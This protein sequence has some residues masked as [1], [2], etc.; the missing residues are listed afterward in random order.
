MNVSIFL[1]NLMCHRCIEVSL[2]AKYTNHIHLT[3]VISQKVF[4]WTQQKLN[5]SSSVSGVLRRVLAALTNWITCWKIYN[6][7]WTNNDTWIT[8]TWKL[9]A[10]SFMLHT[11]KYQ[12]N[13]L[14]LLK[15]KSKTPTYNHSLPTRSFN[16]SY[17]N[18]N[19][20]NSCDNVYGA[21]IIA[22]NC[23]CKS[24]PGSFGHSSTSARRLP[25]FG[26]D[27]SNPPVGSYKYYTNHRHLLLLILKADTH[28]TIPRRVE[29]WVDLAGWLHNKMVYLPVDSHPSQY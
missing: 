18:S 6:S 21:V 27:R 2:M 4:N 5:T 14:T 28:F 25:T 29:G 17:V 15:K 1:A 13:L 24:S 20:S 12:T 11:C 10:G 8:S 9:N 23:N 19:S 7:N 16:F 26:P 22:L 3:S